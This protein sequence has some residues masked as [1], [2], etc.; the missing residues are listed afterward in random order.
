[1]HWERVLPVLPN[2]P[3]Q[4]T[5]A[6]IP[7]PLDLPES[8]TPQQL[9]SLASKSRQRSRVRS[10][11]T[12]SLF[13]S[14][15]GHSSGTTLHTSNALVLT[16]I[17]SYLLYLTTRLVAKSFAGIGVFDLLHN[18][19]AAYFRGVP[20]SS[21]VKVATGLRVRGRREREQ[22]GAWR[23]FGLRSCGGGGAERGVEGAAGVYAVGAA[24]IVAA[25]D[26][27]G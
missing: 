22:L 11:F 3:P 4:D 21:A 8:S 10:T 7:S 18:A 13:L 26:W 6:L 25:R 5:A 17:L 24:G 27:V 19:S 2:L 14:Q 16:N 23:V 1:M 12:T 9:S 15:H 20:P